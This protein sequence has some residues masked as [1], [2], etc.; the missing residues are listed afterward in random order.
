VLHKV[1]IDL[2]LLGNGTYLNNES[3]LVDLLWYTVYCKV[4]PEIYTYI[5]L[6]ILLYGLQFTNWPSTWC[7]QD[8]DWL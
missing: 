5:I 1:E 6:N 3:S 4:L 7:G 2:T 8:G